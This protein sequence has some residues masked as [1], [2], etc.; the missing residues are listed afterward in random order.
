MGSLQGLIAQL[1]RVK[2]I[3]TVIAPRLDAPFKSSLDKAL[4]NYYGSYSPTFY[5]R[6]GN[7][8]NVESSAKAIGA[9]NSVTL[10]ASSDGMS[11]YPRWFSPTPFDASSAFGAFFQNGQH[12]G[13][14][15]LMATST[16]PETLVD[17]DVQ[18]GF[19]GQ[20]GSIVDSTLSS[21][22]G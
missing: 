1:N 19:N 4:H 10:I 21:I 9:G 3:G 12:G 14:R 15:F 7:F 13:G 16:P 5:D 20:L 2:N 11:P 8:M 17:K 22:L 6:T 18:S